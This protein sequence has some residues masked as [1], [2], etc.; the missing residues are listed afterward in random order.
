MRFRAVAQPFRVCCLKRARTPSSTV[1]SMP[2][3]HMCFIG[4]ALAP[5]QTVMSARDN[6]S[7]AKP[8]VRLPTLEQPAHPLRTRTRDISHELL[9]FVNSR[10][11]LRDTE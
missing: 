11:R 5:R 6:P 3:R 1:G 10:G 2:S 9:S 8:S 4:G 7:P